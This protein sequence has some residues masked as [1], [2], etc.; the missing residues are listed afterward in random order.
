ME[1]KKVTN[2]DEKM[3][4]KFRNAV[5]LTYFLTFFMEFFSLG[6]GTIKHKR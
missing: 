2:L 3:E 4:N 5:R 1:N 6:G